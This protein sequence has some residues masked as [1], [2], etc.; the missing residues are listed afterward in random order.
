MTP[1]SHQTLD[2]WENKS[3]V[4]AEDSE[5]KESSNAVYFQ[6]ANLQEFPTLKEPYQS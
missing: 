3:E 1:R 5:P 6:E 2:K 4:D